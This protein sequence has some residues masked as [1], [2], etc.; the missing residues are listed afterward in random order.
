MAAFEAFKDVNVMKVFYPFLY[1]TTETIRKHQ[2]AYKGIEASK[3]FFK[4]LKIDVKKVWTQTFYRQKHLMRVGPTE[5]WRPRWLG[6]QFFE[7]LKPALFD[8]KNS[9]IFIQFNH[10]DNQY[11]TSKKK[12]II[13]CYW[14][15]K[16]QSFER[17][18]NTFRRYTFSPLSASP[19]RCHFVVLALKGLRPVDPLQTGPLAN[20]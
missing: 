13:S 18:Y 2:E 9:S 3:N 16:Q 5:A 6:H 4:V 15:A 12:W 14:L 17:F 20:I 10:F 1:P 11:V 19:T 7:R 8:K